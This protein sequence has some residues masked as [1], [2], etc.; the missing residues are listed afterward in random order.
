MNKKIKTLTFVSLIA[1]L[2]G[3]ASCSSFKPIEVG[4]PK[5][6]Q[7]HSI[8]ANKIKATIFLPIKNPNLFG[9]KV[10]EIDATVFIN[11]K[12]TGN[13]IN[14]E[15]LKIPANSDKTQKLKFEID[16]SDIISGGLSIFKIMNERKVDL[17]LEGTITAKTLFTKREM[18]FN[19]ERTIRLKD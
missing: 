3:F 4:N 11:D 6:V 15:T 12:K 17:R 19:K 2:L 9:V 5:D 1:F 13:V 16:F 8:K 14:S 7:I 10:K 18:D